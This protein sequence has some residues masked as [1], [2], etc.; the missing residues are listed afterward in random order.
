MAALEGEL[1]HQ[2]P[3]IM[4]TSVRSHAWL[5]ECLRERGEFAEGLTCGEEAARIA[6]VA[7]HLSSAIFTQSRLGHLLLHQGNLQRAILVLERALAHDRKERGNQAWGLRLLGDIAAHRD[8]SEAEQA[9]THYRQALT[10]AEEL[11]MRPLQAHCHAGLGRLYAKIGRP[12]PACAELST[13]IDLYRAMD[14]TF[15]LP[16]PRRRWRR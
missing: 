14:M 11:G 3:G 7:G 12:E 6:E 5:V 9:E 4:V 13:A 1:R 2:R 15:W 10:L 8:P 16:R